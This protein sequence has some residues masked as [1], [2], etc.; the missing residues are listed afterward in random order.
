MRG[1]QND[2][3]GF[4][5][6]R[7][8]RTSRVGEDWPQIHWAGMSARSRGWQGE[9]VQAPARPPRRWSGGCA[10][11]MFVWPERGWGLPWGAIWTRQRGLPGESPRHPCCRSPRRSHQSP[12]RKSVRI[13]STVA[14]SAEVFPYW[15][16][17]SRSIT[18]EMGGSQ[19]TMTPWMGLSQTTK[20]DN[21]NGSHSRFPGFATIPC[22]GSWWTGTPPPLQ[23]GGRC[24][25]RPWR[26]TEY[27]PGR[28]F[29]I[30]I[31]VLNWGRNG[32]LNH[33]FV[34]T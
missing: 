33:G 25:I 16:P 11:W 31:Q 19:F 13:D 4:P 12:G 18:W 17:P 8:N 21:G 5:A 27:V 29:A 22:T 15:I 14:R 20:N 7:N 3:S 23:D 28:Q 10:P 24:R 9:A 1:A 2:C 6:H 26:N 32:C 34:S 30:F